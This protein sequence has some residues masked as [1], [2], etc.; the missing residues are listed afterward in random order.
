MRHILQK[1][2]VVPRVNDDLSLVFPYQIVIYPE[3]HGL[4]LLDEW[5]NFYRLAIFN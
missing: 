5:V 2:D 1:S 4:G 3:N